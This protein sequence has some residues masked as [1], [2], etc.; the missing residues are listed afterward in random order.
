MTVD[1]PEDRDVQKADDFVS[2]MGV[3]EVC[4]TVIDGRVLTFREYPSIEMANNAL[5]HQE[6][7]GVNEEV[8]KLED[9][10]SVARSMDPPEE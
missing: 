10:V 2:P 5:L 8:G 9:I 6:Y 4:Y 1:V 7:L 3:R